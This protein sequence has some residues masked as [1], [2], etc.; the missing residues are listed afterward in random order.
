MCHCTPKQARDVVFSKVLNKSN[1]PNCN[2]AT[3]KQM[4]AQLNIFTLKLLVNQ[5]RAIIGI[6]IYIYIIHGFSFILLQMPNFIFDI[7]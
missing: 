7:F 2:I 5:P 4:I 3:F 6:Y 1:L